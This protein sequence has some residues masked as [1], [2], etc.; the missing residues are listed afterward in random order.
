MSNSQHGSE[1]ELESWRRCRRW[2]R[3]E[4]GR[5]EEIRASTTS[6][7]RTQESEEGSRLECKASYRNSKL[8]VSSSIVE[9]GESQGLFVDGGRIHSKSGTSEATRGKISGESDFSLFKVNFNSL[10]LGI[11]CSQEERA[12]VD[13]LRGTPMGVGTLEEM[14][15]DNHA[16]VSSSV[17][18]KIYIDSLRAALNTEYYCRPRIV[19][20]YFEFCGS[21]PF[22]AWK[23]RAHPQQGV[24]ECGYPGRRH[25]PLGQRYEGNL[26]RFFMLCYT[27]T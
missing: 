24:V 1:P 3:E 26:H 8:K 16:I 2:P 13:E 5:K 23:L 17:G 21:R 19:R 22:G 7:D 4:E 27:R 25:G 12:K 10:P 9:A 6:K 11:L 20:E 15:D 14:I 18:M